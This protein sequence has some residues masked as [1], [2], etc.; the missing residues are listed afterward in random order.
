ARAVRPCNVRSPRRP[1]AARRGGASR[2][3]APAPRSQRR[4]PGWRKLP[5]HGR[6]SAAPSLVQG[7]GI[8][9]SIFLTPL[10]VQKQGKRK[11]RF[12]NQNQKLE[13][14]PSRDGGYQQ[15]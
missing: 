12:R 13:T 5:V 1:I 11:G 15:D 6:R 7:L 8:R 9:F 10:V 14:L 2:G 3:R 4:S